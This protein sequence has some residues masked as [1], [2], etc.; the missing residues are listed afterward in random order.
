M[1]VQGSEIK[2][3]GSNEIGNMGKIFHTQRRDKQKRRRETDNN[4]E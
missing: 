3:E 2:E 4:A 1:Q